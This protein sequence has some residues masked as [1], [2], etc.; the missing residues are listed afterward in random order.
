MNKLLTITWSYN[1]KFPIKETFLFK[2]FIKNNKEADFIHI[3]FNRNNYKRLEEEFNSKY[4]FQYEYLLYKIFLA[5]DFIRTIDAE[6]IIFCDANDTVCLGSIEN[7][8][9]RQNIL[10]SSEINQYPSSL[11]DW[12]GLDYSQE[13]RNNKWFLNAGLFIST[14][15]NY[16]LL[17][18]SVIKNIF[19]KNLKSFG[20]DQG[21]F[22]FH[23]LSN[24]NPKIELDKSN[25]LFFCSF[26]RD[27]NA[28]KR[29]DFPQFV[30]DNGWNWGSPR[31]IEKFSLI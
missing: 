19:P 28:F 10:F 5:L 11:G 20:G 7:I 6:N 4:G 8:V 22:L 27:Y 14:K 2:S 29:E 13:D 3:H 31:F 30:H 15:V 9:S 17:L 12:G 16:I 26:S 18:E 21:V 1:D 25:S 24:S 23:Y